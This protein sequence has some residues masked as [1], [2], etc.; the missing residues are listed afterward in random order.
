MARLSLAPIMVFCV[1]LFGMLGTATEARGE[2][3]TSPRIA[4]VDWTIA[5]TLMALGAPPTAMAQV[6]EYHAWVEQP[7]MPD[8]VVDL[9]LRA[10]P[11]RE[12]AASLDLDQFLLSPLFAALEPTLSQI[13]PVTTLSTYRPDSDLWQNLLETTRQL[14]EIVGKPAA[15]DRVITEHQQRIKQVRQS[16][17]NTLPPLLV[18]QFIDNRHVRVYGEGSLYNM[19]LDRL[20]LTNAWQGGTNLWGYSTAGIEELTQEG[21]LVVVDPM[22]MGVEGH[23]DANSLWKLLTAVQSDRVIHLPAV[24]S[25]GALPSAVRFAEELGQALTTPL[26]RQGATGS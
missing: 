25:F 20:G 10:Q 24:W 12:L 1:A 19:V 22:P 3:A 6:A 21:Y 16:L 15:A 23:L 17:P 2:D 26:F 11:N 14:G 4:T 7:A 8:S 18:V 13:A 9:G 5:E